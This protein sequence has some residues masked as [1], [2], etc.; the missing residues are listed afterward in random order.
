MTIIY[1]PLKTNMYDIP[2]RV[3][4]TREIQ[5][6]VKNMG[7]PEWEYSISLSTTN[8]HMI[9]WFEHDEHATAFALRWG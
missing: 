6:W 1:A 9:A 8:L 4:E 3:A 2:G 7:W 5:E